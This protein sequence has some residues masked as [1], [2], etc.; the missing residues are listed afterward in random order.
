MVD[1]S[2]VSASVTPPIPRQPIGGTFIVAISLLGLFALVQLIAVIL[3][4]V[5][6]VRSQLLEQQRQGANEEPYR[7]ALQ[8]APT[9]LEQS[10]PASTP[11]AVDQALE[12]RAKAI[13]DDADKNFRLGDY[14]STLNLLREAESMLPAN[15]AIQFRLGLVFESLNDK[16]QAFESYERSLSFPGLDSEIQRKA[17]KKMALLAQ[18]M[19]DAR[20][21]TEGNSTG[22]GMAVRDEVG[23]QPGAVLGI[24]ESRLSDSR[25]GE[26]TLRVAVKSRPG[27]KIDNQIM[28]VFA[29]FYEED[30]NGEIVTTKANVQNRWFSPPIDWADGEPE[31]LDITYPT[32]DGK[33]PGN[34]SEFGE[35]GRKFH[36]YVLGVYYNGELQDARAEPGKLDTMFP[37]PLYEKH[38]AE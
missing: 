20:A 18:T 6:I 8:S 31:I 25:P 26:K 14:N 27:T 28:R 9:Q 19:G 36:G 7:P 11:V 5:P 10:S 13:V 23:L 21:Q 3:H 37:L 34:S 22:G 35:P 2:S 24:V 16:V 17:E 38:A 33:L 12:A 30:E 1:Y 29:Y 15:P 4:F 32:P